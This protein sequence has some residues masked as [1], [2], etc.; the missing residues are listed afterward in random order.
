[1]FKILLLFYL[2]WQCWSRIFQT[3]MKLSNLGINKG[4]V[5]LDKMT[6]A[7]GIVSVQ[8]M[9]ILSGIPYGESGIVT[10]EAIPEEKW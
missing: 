3:S 10:I 9:T 7:P 5:Y 1:M 8:V 4:W 2:I 6:F